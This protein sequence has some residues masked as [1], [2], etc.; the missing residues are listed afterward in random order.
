[1]QDKTWSAMCYQLNASLTNYA[2][3]IAESE[4]RS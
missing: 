1:M 4:K 2:T 3:A